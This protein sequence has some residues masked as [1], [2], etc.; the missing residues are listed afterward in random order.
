MERGLSARQLGKL[1]AERKKMTENENGRRAVSR[2]LAGEGIS[3]ENAEHLSA[4]F[5]KPLDYFKKPPAEHR[6][7][8]PQPPSEELAALREQVREQEL[9][10]RALE[11][12]RQLPEP[13]LQA[14]GEAG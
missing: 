5:D 12:R 3:D 8:K 13:G 6:W 7:P 1:L 10:L 2:W 4:I 14:Q 11:E 9:R